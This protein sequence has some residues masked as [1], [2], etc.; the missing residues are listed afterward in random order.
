MSTYNKLNEV[1]YDFKMQFK[2]VFSIFLNVYVEKRFFLK[3]NFI[4]TIFLAYIIMFGPLS[5]T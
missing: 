3:L 1:F 2:L 5:S 4:K